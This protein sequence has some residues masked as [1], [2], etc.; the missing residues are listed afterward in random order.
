MKKIGKIALKIFAIYFILK[1]GVYWSMDNNKNDNHNSNPRAAEGTTVS[2]KSASSSSSKPEAGVS[3]KEA[4]LKYLSEKYPDDTFSYDGPIGGN[5]GSSYKKVG[6]HSQKYPDA[7]FLY[8]I[9]GQTK[10]TGEWVYADNYLYYKYEKESELFFNEVLGDVFDCEYRA[11][12]VGYGLMNPLTL[13]GSATFEDF[14]C[15]PNAD[16][17]FSAFVSPGNEP[18][19][20]DA[21]EK[22]LKKAFLERGVHL[23]GASIYFMSD[24]A[25]YQTIRDAVTEDEV[26]FTHDAVYVRLGALGTVRE[27]FNWGVLDGTV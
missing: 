1:M 15:C 18:E 5:V 14:I 24:S 25:D 23:I 9:Y 17:S 7:E 27:R 11:F 3:T 16:I 20:R 4:M 13:P 10:D 19:D 6:I 2:S 21:F 8:A 26:C 12:G 22:K